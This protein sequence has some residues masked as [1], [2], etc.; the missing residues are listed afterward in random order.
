M[1]TNWFCRNIPRVFVVG[2]KLCLSDKLWYRYNTSSR[3]LG[4]QYQI[5]ISY[6]YFFRFTNFRLSRLPYDWNHRLL[7]VASVC[8]P[9]YAEVLLTYIST[10]TLTN[11]SPLLWFL[12]PDTPSSRFSQCHISCIILRSLI[13]DTLLYILYLAEL[14]KTLVGM[15]ELGK[16]L[17]N[18]S[19]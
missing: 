15:A 11:L 5:P 4:L 8:S 7:T 12:T 1:W 6:R 10:S 19:H 16:L 2:K 3:N 13:K 17:E 18:C 14:V 9:F